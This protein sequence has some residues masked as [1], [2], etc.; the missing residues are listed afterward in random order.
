MKGW[1][2][3][4]T[5]MRSAGQ[6]QS[7]IRAC[8]WTLHQDILSRCRRP[9]SR[10]RSCSK[11]CQIMWHSSVCQPEGEAKGVWKSRLV[12]LCSIQVAQVSNCCIP[13]CTATT[14]PM[15][16]RS[17]AMGLSAHTGAAG[18]MTIVEGSTRPSGTW[19]LAPARILMLG[20]LCPCLC[21]R[22]FIMD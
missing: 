5:V 1:A 2:G 9:S 13:A 8:N 10:S 7:D 4:K 11:V 6:Q 17:P 18:G 21:A 12:D 22:Q 19:G 20:G 3:L 15:P 16:A 14:W